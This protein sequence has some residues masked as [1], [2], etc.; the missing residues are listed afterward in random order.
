VKGAKRYL[1]VPELARLLSM[2]ELRV[3]DEETGGDVT[4]E[5]LR[6]FIALQGRPDGAPL[7]L[8]RGALGKLTP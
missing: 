7:E 2:Q 8:F 6:R 4:R 1:S 5:T 3:V